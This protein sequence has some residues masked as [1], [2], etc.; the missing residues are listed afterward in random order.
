MPRHELVVD[1]LSLTLSRVRRRHTLIQLSAC[2]SNGLIQFDT[3]EPRLFSENFL[4]L[5]VD[6]LIAQFASTLAKIF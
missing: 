3:V 6:S 4:T 5:D 1:Y 2:K